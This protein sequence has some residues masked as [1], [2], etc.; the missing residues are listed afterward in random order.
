MGSQCDFIPPSIPFTMCFFKPKAHPIGNFKFAH[1]V[2]GHR[3]HIIASKIVLV[4]FHLDIISR[5][6]SSHTQIHTQNLSSLHS[7]ELTIEDPN[8]LMSNI[9]LQTKV[10]KLE[11]LMT[12]LT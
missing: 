4:T 9:I 8:K 10:S 7:D 3:W 11:G 2:V 6:Y 12:K 5:V 1:N